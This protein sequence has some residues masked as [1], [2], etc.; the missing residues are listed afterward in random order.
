MLGS[1]RGVLHP[2]V[3]KSMRI[4]RTESLVKFSR[5]KGQAG[6]SREE[7]FSAMVEQQ[8]E[9]RTCPGEMVKNIEKTGKICLPQGIEWGRQ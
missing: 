5:Q 2:L 6:V 7:V 9:Q 8:L 1:R 4:K 3:L